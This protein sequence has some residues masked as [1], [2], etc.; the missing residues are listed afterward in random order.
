MYC[1]NRWQEFGQREILHMFVYVCLIGCIS[2]KKSPGSDKN[3]QIQILT[4]RFK[5]LISYIYSKAL[6]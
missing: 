6:R 1:V 3:R 2:P 5:N 4:N